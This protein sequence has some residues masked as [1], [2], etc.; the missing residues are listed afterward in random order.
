MALVQLLGRVA[1]YAIDHASASHRGP[2]QNR[3]GP[4]LHVLVVLHR[5][6][7]GRAVLPAFGQAAIPGEYRDVGDGVVATGQIF[8]FG[9]A[10][11]QHVEL[12]LDLHGVAVDGVFALDGRIRVEVATTIGRAPV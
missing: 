7:L 6:E 8:V 10:A 4:A 1:G 12:A 11:V 2:R 9:Q 5:Q 3:V